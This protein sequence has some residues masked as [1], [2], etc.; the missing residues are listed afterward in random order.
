MRKKWCWSASHFFVGFNQ[1]THKRTKVLRKRFYWCVTHFSSIFANPPSIYILYLSLTHSNLMSFTIAKKCLKSIELT[2]FS[3]FSEL[4]LRSSW[5][6]E[7][8]TAI[9]SFKSEVHTRR[10]GILVAESNFK[11]DLRC[12]NHLIKFYLNDFFL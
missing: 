8:W 10:I 11:R 5:T 3:F 2:H 9:N 1:H 7:Q 6:K 12:G 4:N